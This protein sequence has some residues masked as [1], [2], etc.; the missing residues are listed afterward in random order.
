MAG[1]VVLLGAGLTAALVAFAAGADPGA[2]SA[3]DLVRK[4]LEAYSCENP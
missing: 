2:A 4:R 1:Q 3:A